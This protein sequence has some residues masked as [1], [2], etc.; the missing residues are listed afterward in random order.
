VAS[1][2][3]PPGD[4]VPPMTRTAR[5]DTGA[6][7]AAAGDP[8]G[9]RGSGRPAGIRAAGGAQAGGG[10][11]KSAQPCGNTRHATIWVT[12]GPSSRES[13]PQPTQIAPDT[14]HSGDCAELRGR[15]AEGEERGGGRRCDV[16]ARRRRRRPRGQA[17]GDN[18]PHRNPDQPQPMAVPWIT[19]RSGRV[20]HVTATAPR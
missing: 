9:R 6:V 3:A 2:R 12:C 11:R 19:Q 8:G 20:I 7:Q 10:A 18:T 14:D 15:S 17:G 1:V 4:P 16:S 13:G 5:R